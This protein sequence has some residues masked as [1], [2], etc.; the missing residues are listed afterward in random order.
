MFAA[1]DIDDI[2]ARLLTHGAKLLGE[3]AQEV[4]RTVAS[5]RSSRRA[6]WVF[7]RPTCTMGMI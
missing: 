1:D 5:E 3:V 7:E 2:D 4:V 6:I